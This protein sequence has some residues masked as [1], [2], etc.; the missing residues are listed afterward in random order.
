[1]RRSCERAPGRASTCN[2]DGVEAGYR[3]RYED[4]SAETELR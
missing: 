3:T 2:P 4:F 1:V